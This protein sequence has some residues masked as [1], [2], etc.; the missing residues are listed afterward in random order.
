MNDWK[1]YID[2]ILTM[3]KDGAPAAW[4][5]LVHGRVF[6]GALTLIFAA[7]PLMALVTVCAWLA[8]AGVRNLRDENS[9][10]DESDVIAGTAVCII[11]GAVALISASITTVDGLLAI[12]TPEYSLLR[13][14]MP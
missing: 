5:T 7:I 8:R 2:E 10:H 3:L 6:E 4:S 11:V 14:L 1:P 13:K 12:I 9:H